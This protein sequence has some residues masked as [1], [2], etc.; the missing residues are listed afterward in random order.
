MKI[1]HFHT[2]LA[3]GGIEAMICG[4]AN[5]MVAMGE[6]VTVGTVFA[7]VEGDSFWHR[8]SSNVKTFNL[9]KVQKGFSVK[10]LFA[11]YRA[12]KRGNYD[13]VNLHGSLYYYILAVTMLHQRVHFFY[14]VHSDATMENAVWDMRLLWLK[15]W[16]FRRGWV[17][18]IT[19]S[20]VSQVSFAQFYGCKSTLIYN[21]IE[22][23]EVD[24]T[25]VMNN[26]WQLTPQT[27]I[28]LHPGRITEAKNQLVLCRVFQR[29]IDEGHDVV[30][31][32]AGDNRDEQIF[33]K[34]KP[35]FS[36]RIVFLGQRDDV[37]QL[38]AHAAGMCL[39]SIWEGL[40][41]TLLE[42]LSVGCIPICS[43]V[44]GIVNVVKDG[45]N[46]LLARSSQEDDYYDAMHHFLAMSPEKRA[47]MRRAALAS[48]EQYDIRET[49]RNYI[50]TYQSAL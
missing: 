26:A 12:M 20:D 41:V 3:S 48:F 32:I 18:A 28:F 5:G 33:N 50:N 39:P 16:M 10:E 25:Y 47:S 23:P 22:R 15:K 35:F 30:L 49:A 46:G 31:L 44:G 27:Q 11:V 42:A 1:L 14:T 45:G 4:L 2:S 13:V 43:P 7:P 38:L 24:L 29:L 19:I 6:D 34:L 8:L 17:R 36:K 37:P 9:G 21:G 40:P